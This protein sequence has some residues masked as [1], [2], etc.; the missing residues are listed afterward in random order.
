MTEFHA[1]DYGLFVTQSDRI[2][3][4]YREGALNGISIFAN[5][6]ELRQCLEMLPE[7]GLAITAHLN[8]MQG[9][10]SADKETVNL[11]VDKTGCFSISF[12][13]LL[14]CSLTGKREEYKQQIKKEFRAQILA[15]LPVFQKLNQPLRL[16]GHAHWHL[17]PVA[18]DAM[19]EVISEEKLDVRYIRIPAEPLRIYI[20]HFFEIIPFPLINIIKTVLLKILAIRDRR[21]WKKELER[22]DK[23]LFFGVLLSGCFD[24]RR[25][26]AILPSAESMASKQGM[27]LELLAH[28]GA[29]YEHM[30]IARLTNDSDYRFLTSPAREVEAESFL[31]LRSKLGAEKTNEPYER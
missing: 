12:S 30:D 21:H 5:G 31:K 13:R 2:L 3:R 8:L 6:E 27:G 19:M 23:K 4:C 20:Y 1:D 28:P 22:L 17:L 9:Y 26:C 10:C 16:D 11:L 18:F 14:F 25:F 24:Y 15:L 29:V 7:K